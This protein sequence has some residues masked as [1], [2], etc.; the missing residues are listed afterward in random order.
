[1]NQL[2]LEIARCPIVQH[3]LENPTTRHECA[4][5]VRLQDANSYHAHQV[6][7][8]W[9][10]NLEQAPI[11]FLSSNPSISG[12]DVFPTGSWTDEQI[13]DYFHNRFAERSQAW[14]KGGTK[15]LKSDG[16]YLRATKFWAFVRK[17]AMEL[18][19]REVHPGVDYALTEIVHCKSKAEH[20]VVEAQQQCA[21]RYLQRILAASNA[22]VIVVL[23]QP[24][25]RAIEAKF[26]IPRN[27]SMSGPIACCGRERVFT[28]LPHS[29]AWENKTF[30][31]CLSDQE[32]Q[33]VRAFLQT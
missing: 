18:L 31:K 33:V 12:E 16:T 15:A 10:G 22:A 13:V 4:T 24:A 25:R 21:E 1:M 30:S 32:L 5:I 28:F 23:G 29:N 11:L 7:E 19:E 27:V 8:P 26:G 9:S 6:P 17:R 14:I 3:C 2:L 20:G